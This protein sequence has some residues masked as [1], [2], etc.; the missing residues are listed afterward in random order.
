MNNSIVTDNNNNNQVIVRCSLASIKEL[1]LIKTGGEM[2][3]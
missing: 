3:R 1:I 2:I